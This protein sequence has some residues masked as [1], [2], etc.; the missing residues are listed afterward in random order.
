MKRFALPLAVALVLGTAATASA[1]VWTSYYAPVTTYYAPATSASVVTGSPM[2]TTVY[3]SAPAPVT[4]Y[5]A[6][7][8]V[9]P[10]T[11]YYAPTPVTSYYAPAVA[12][13]VYARPGFF[14]PRVVRYRYW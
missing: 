5:Y 11:T 2:P 6:P 13:P 14:R 8:V 1:Q 3:Y 7:S 4:T 12:Y 9:E 10:V